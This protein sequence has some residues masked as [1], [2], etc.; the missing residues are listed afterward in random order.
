MTRLTLWLLYFASVINPRGK[1]AAARRTII[2]SYCLFSHFSD[3]DNRMLLLLLLVVERG[4][5]EKVLTQSRKKI[6]SAL[7]SVAPVNFWILFI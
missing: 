3:Y 4:W 5:Q 7:E 2:H 1:M 6:A